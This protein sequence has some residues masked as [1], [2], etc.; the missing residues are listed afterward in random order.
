M[1]SVDIKNFP[2][3][4]TPPSVSTQKSPEIIPEERSFARITTNM[5]FF[6]TLGEAVSMKQP[7]K[8][9]SRSLKGAMRKK[10]NPWGQ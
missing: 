10:T 2:A 6:P 9:A 1:K 5:G 8:G 3:V 4:G 7:T